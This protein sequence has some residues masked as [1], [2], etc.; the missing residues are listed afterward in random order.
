MARLL[1]TATQKQRGFPEASEPLG[2]VEKHVT[3]LGSGS[4]HSPTQEEV[5]GLGW[6]CPGPSG[7][8]YYMQRSLSANQTLPRLMQSQ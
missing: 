8:N 7:G 3:G 5:N 2:S 4:S 6:V 1:C